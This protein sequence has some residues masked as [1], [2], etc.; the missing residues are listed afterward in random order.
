MAWLRSEVDASACSNVSGLV[1][2]AANISASRNGTSVT[3]SF[4]LYAKNTGQVSYND[5]CLWTNNNY[6]NVHAHGSATVKNTNYFAGGYDSYTFSL[7]ANVSSASVSIGVNQTVW[8]PSTPAGYVTLT[9]DGLPTASAPSGVSCKVN[10][11]TR[12]SATLAG[13]VSSWGSYASSSSSSYQWGTSTSY[14]KTGA[15]MTGLTPNTTY[16]YKYTATNNAGLSTAVTGNFKTT[17]N[18]P[19]IN[20]FIATPSRTECSFEYDVTYDTNDSF[21]SIKIE[22]GTSTNYGSSVSTNKITGLQP[23]K[24]Y[25]FAATIT[26]AT[27]RTNTY[28]G[29]FMTTGNA[30]KVTKVNIIEI[31]SKTLNYQIIG[32]A[33]TNA[34]ISEYRTTFKLSDGTGSEIK[35]TSTKDTILTDEVFRPGKWYKGAVSVVDSFNRVSANYSLEIKFKG[36]FKFEGKMSDSARFNNKEVAGI[37]FNGVDII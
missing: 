15:S 4:Q 8:N 22:Y 37:R 7:A 14:G 19:V 33:D 30:P 31:K 1:V 34:T 32:E 3:V 21:S 11:I 2:G 35:V 36:G 23:N 13:S 27:G 26:A 20:S 10:N 25:Y 18:V 24:K 9:F 6:W 5:L 28:V 29:E 17:G 16:Y 12:T